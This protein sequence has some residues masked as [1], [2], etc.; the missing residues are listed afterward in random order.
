[1]R[2]VG[3]CGR[4]ANLFGAQI[5]SMTVGRVRRRARLRVICGPMGGKHSVANFEVS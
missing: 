3:D 5:L 1:M 2:S 4:G